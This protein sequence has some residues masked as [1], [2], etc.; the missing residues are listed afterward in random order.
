MATTTMQKNG[1]DF[2]VLTVGLF[3]GVFTLLALMVAAW[4]PDP[5]F[6]I[7]GWLS[8]G[9]SLV[10]ILAICFWAANRKDGKLFDETEYEDT[11][12]KWGVGVSM[13]WG[14]VGILVGFVIAMQLTFPSLLYFEEFG[15]LNFGRLRPLHT[16][17]VIFAFGGN[18]LLATS[19]HVV[20][21]TCRTRIAGGM[22]PWFVF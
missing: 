10:A 7:H 19:F 16:S 13:F 4:S 1:I 21:R 18:V 20:Q 3:V 15:F 17:A 8:L 11:L 9:M 2:S 22:W 5:L 12:I 14:V 6:N